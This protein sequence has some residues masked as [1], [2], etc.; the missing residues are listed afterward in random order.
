MRSFPFESFANRWRQPTGIAILNGLRGAMAISD[1]TDRIKVTC[2]CGASLMA[3]RKAVGKRLKCPRC[4]KV[5]TVPDPGSTV[6]RLIYALRDEEYNKPALEQQ[7]L[8]PEP[9]TTAKGKLCPRCNAEMG[10]EA[11]FCIKC[12]FHLTHGSS[13]AAANAA[14]AGG[15]KAFFQRLF[16]RDK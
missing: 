7:P 16:K 5:I 11:I 13:L 2:N 12:G 15:L 6:D 4:A 3:P 8:P 14:Q 10:R 1:K 9:Q